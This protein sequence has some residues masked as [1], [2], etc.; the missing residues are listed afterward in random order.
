MKVIIIK[1]LQ[2]LGN[3]GDTVKVKDGY[4]RNYL[5]PR[6]FALLASQDNTDR[7]ESIKKKRLRLAED[8]KKTFIDLKEKIEKISLTLTAEVKED[9]ELYGS[10]HETQI[11]KALSEEG[12]DLS[13]DKLVLTEAIKKLGVYN[14]RVKLHSEVEA[15]L[16]VWIVKK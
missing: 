8:K 6:G 1:E 10:I 12:I 5:I 4:A 11:I 2:G 15:N 16:R 9:E 7:L 13:K 3:V 14:V